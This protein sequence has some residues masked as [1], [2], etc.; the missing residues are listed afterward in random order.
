M[1]RRSHLHLKFYVEHWRR[2]SSGS[3]GELQ[4]CWSC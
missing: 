2:W 1:T 3:V 4:K